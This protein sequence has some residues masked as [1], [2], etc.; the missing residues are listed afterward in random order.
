MRATLASNLSTDIA[1]RLNVDE[2][3]T[4]DVIVAE[5]HPMFSVDEKLMQFAEDLPCRC[6]IVHHL[7]VDDPLLKVI[8]GEWIEGVLEQLGMT[9][10]GRWV[11]EEQ[12]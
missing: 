1:N 2:S 11:S 9:E 6:R 7:S 10:D 3:A 8:A 4:I 5:R 12:R